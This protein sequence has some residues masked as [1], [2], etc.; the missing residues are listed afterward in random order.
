MIEVL[1]QRILKKESNNYK[2]TK[3]NQNPDRT[4]KVDFYSIKVSEDN[5]EKNFSDKNSLFTS[6]T[7]GSSRMNAV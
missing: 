1:R 5:D 6:K 4:K 2:N 7:L 3:S